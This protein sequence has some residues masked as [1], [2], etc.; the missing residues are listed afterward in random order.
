MSE[1][2]ATPM[3]AAGS[4]SGIKT[5]IDDLLGPA[6]RLLLGTVAVFGLWAAFVP[7][8]AAVVAPGTVI[9]SGQNKAL[10]HRSGGIV[11]A[12]HVQEGETVA[13][14]AVILELDPAVD[15]AELTRLR[16]RH[17]VLSALKSRLEAEKL[18]TQPP[19][20]KGESGAFTPALRLKRDPLTTGTV[21]KPEPVPAP[22]PAESP[23]RLEQERE[24]IKGRHLLAAELEAL[25]QKGEA[26]RRQHEGAVNRLRHVKK[27]VALLETQHKAAASLERRGHIAKQQV[28]DIESKLL[29]RRA[30]LVALTSESAALAN[31]IEENASLFRQVTFKD[32]RENSGKLT[33]VLGELAQ[34]SDQLKAAEAALAQT[35]IRA[36][37]SGTLVR[38]TAVTIGGVVKP[39]DIVGE[40]VPEDAALEVEARVQPKDMAVIHTG[41]DAK[42]KI[43]ALAAT[44][45]DPLLAKVTYVAA[46]S[47]QDER[48]GERFFQ[49]RVAL[50]KDAASAPRLR[51]VAIGMTGDVYL[52]AEPRTFLSY[53]VRPVRDSLARAFGEAK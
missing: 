18:F 35:Q 23:I 52:Q 53:L 10:Q 48:S 26:L 34:I 33:E 24:F 32:E 47:S 31:S 43:S 22:A 1:L 28:W 46:D 38:S 45:S 29:D 12:I 44:N 3:P 42:V 9:S 8:E 30:E 6:G 40:I 13:A 2:D 21:A 41:Q 5:D 15:R 14:G 37:V 7:M 27:Q 11:R 19:S 50:K 17:T 25:R 20:D 51:E 39:A 4:F 16:A 36:P 49:V